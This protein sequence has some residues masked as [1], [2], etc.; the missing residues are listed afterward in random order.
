MINALRVDAT[1]AWGFFW[2]RDTSSKCLLVL[3]HDVGAAPEG[4][5]PKLKGIEIAISDG[6]GHEGRMLVFRLLDSAQRDIFHRLCRDIV[7]STTNANSER[8]AVA[9]ALARTWRWHHLLRGGRDG[10]LS[11]EEQKGLLGELLVLERYLLPTFEA[12]DALSTWRGPLGAPK[13]FEIGSVCIEA[14]A[15]RGNAAPFVAIS[16]E[17]QLDDG[18]AA[19]VFLHVA[20][21]DQAPSDA[22]DTVSLTMA[23]TRLRDSVAAA[24]KRASDMFDTLLEAAGFSWDDDYSDSLWIVG[25]THIY[26][27]E[28]AFP[29][30]K[31]QQIASGISQVRYSLSLVECEPFC[32]EEAALRIALEKVRHGA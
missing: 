22:A 5:L 21:L 3:R 14:K 9:L 7:A 23:A 8:E 1:I 20:E 4:H 26:H 29:R 31:A 12:F 2:A 13:D 11:G 6:E 19:A 18:A 17:H 32:V 28:G 25:A 16:S 24:D 15:R 27:V 10:R 30:I